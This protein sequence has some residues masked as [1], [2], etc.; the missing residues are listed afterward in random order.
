MQEI[1]DAQL[2]TGNILNTGIAILVGYAL[3]EFVYIYFYKKYKGRK[4]YHQTTVNFVFVIAMNMLVG[5]LIG[6]FSTSAL[7]VLAYPHA[8]FTTSLS[9]H[10]WIYGW[11]VYEL[12]YWIQHWLAHKVRLLWCLHS[13]HHAPE[14]MN[15]FVGFNHSFLEVMF[16]MPFFLGFLPT[17]FGV[18]PVIVFIL[19]LI[20][21]IWGNLLHI[22]D[23]IVNKRYGVLER[24][25]QTPSYHRVHHAQNVRYMDT[26]YNSITLFWDWVFGT[27]Q[28]LQDDEVVKYG[29]TRDVNT[30][31][32]F[33]VQFGDF[34]LL[35]KDIVK[36][37]T[38]IDKLKYAIYPPGWSH[39][40][41]HQG[42]VSEL[43]KTLD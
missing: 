37:P 33:D 41:D 7:S 22:D 30:Q 36:A 28:E 26:N 38:L 11:L 19:I 39:T 4:D 40:G 25:L 29:I 13:P 9:W 12:F 32:F 31:N 42:L 1:L 43:K 18:H 17:L 21:V 8:L 15:L 34:V 27:K 20:D 5:A 14:S 6:V 3:I 2:Q 16:Y 35:A 23:H 24:F 10:W